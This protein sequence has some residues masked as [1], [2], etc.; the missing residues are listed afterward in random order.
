[1]LYKVFLTPFTDLSSICKQE[2]LLVGF[3]ESHAELK[4]DQQ[5]LLYVEI[6]TQTGALFQVEPEFVIKKV[7]KIEENVTNLHFQK[8]E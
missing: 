2:E 4:E 3:F 5:I 7:K 8:A 6:K 1:M